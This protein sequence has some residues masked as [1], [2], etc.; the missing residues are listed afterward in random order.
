M[1]KEHSFGFV[2]FCLT[3]LF[4]Y[5]NVKKKHLEMSVLQLSLFLANISLKLKTGTQQINVIII[6]IPDPKQRQ[7]TL[8]SLFCASLN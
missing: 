5:F 2:Y 8:L 1:L 6:N 4:G 7:K 3:V